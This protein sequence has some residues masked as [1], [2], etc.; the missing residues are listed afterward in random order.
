MGKSSVEMVKNLFF[1]KKYERGK[2][3][4][5]IIFAEEIV[6]MMTEKEVKN[7]NAQNNK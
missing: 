2:K 4:K 5:L 3:E 6:K 1:E 7:Q